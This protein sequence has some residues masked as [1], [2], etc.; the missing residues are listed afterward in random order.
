MSTP[1]RHAKHANVLLDTRGQTSERVHAAIDEILKFGGC[2]H[3][4]QL[5]LFRV[6]FVS[7]PPAELAKHGILSLEQLGP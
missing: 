6:D 1:S 2:L 3:C 5:A 4:G 7:D